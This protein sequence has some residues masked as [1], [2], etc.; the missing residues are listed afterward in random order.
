LASGKTTAASQHAYYPE[1]P[2]IPWLGYPIAAAIDL[3][4]IEG[5]YH[6]T[7]EVIAGAIIGTTIGYITGKNFRAEYE[8]RQNGVSEDEVDEYRRKKQA[9]GFF[10]SPTISDGRYAASVTWY[11]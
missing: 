3:G 5:D 4:M 9:L 1:H 10:V 8:R 2:W 11:W 6:W 7:P